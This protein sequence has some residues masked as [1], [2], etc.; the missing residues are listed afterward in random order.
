MD[1]ERLLGQD[2]NALM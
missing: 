1:E 2:Q